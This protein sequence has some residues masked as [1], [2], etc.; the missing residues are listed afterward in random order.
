MEK[1]MSDEAEKAKQG[2]GGS[3]LLLVLVILNGLAIAGAG[4]AIFFALSARSATQA[5]NDKE[6][7]APA[8]PPTTIAGIGPT[9]VFDTF[10][11]N[12]DE[13][14]GNRYLKLQIT[15]ELTADAAKAVLESEMPKIRDTLIAF[16]SNQRMADVRGAAG[17]ERVREG[18]HERILAMAPGAIRQVFLTDFVVQ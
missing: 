15:I 16:L 5:P 17:K 4:A 18:I 12:L 7:V 8:A 1:T 14:E 3:K 10:V 2:G 6:A 13:P 11:V 9:M